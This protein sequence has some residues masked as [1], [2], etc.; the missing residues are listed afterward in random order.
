MNFTD[1][2][3]QYSTVLQSTYGGLLTGNSEQDAWVHREAEEMQ[4][5]M[6]IDAIRDV[7]INAV[8]LADRPLER[9]AVFH[10]RYGIAHRAKFI[11]V[12]LRRLVAQ[13]P[14]G[15]TEP[16][17]LDD[18]EALASDLNV[19]YLNIR[20]ALD[21]LAWTLRAV[22]PSPATAALR[23]VNMDLFGERFLGAIDNDNLRDEL[24]PFRDWYTELK[25][26]RDPAAHRIPLSVPPT[27]LDEVAL[28]EYADLDRQYGAAMA[29]ALSA[30]R[31]GLDKNPDQPLDLK[32]AEEIG[33]LFEETKAIHAK[34]QKI[35]KFPG[36][37]AHHPDE[38]AMPIYP[39]VP[40][41]VRNLVAIARI[42][43]GFIPTPSAQDGATP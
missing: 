27:I 9:D 32:S 21:N 11:W 34:R 22:T 3:L 39:T 6:V 23:D 13:A 35:G 4:A 7:A 14:P 17:P 25:S 43:A 30:A 36:F 33:L 26:R 12:S 1:D 28:Q 16:M 29:K 5:L 15:R 41:D 19:I 38:V 31:H 24:E 10:L 40:E 42:I 8:V 18:V 20:G 2:R 37:F